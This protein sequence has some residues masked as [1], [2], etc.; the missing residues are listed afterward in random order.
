[1]TPHHLFLNDDV[2]KSFDTNTKMNPPLGNEE[3]RAA[4]E[5]ALINGI[6]DCV[7]TD[8]APHTETEKQV[9]YSFAPNG[10]IGLET[11]LS[12]MLTRL[13]HTKKM[14]PMQM[15]QVMSSNPAN[16]LGINAGSLKRESPADIT[17]IDPDRFWMVDPQA[18]H[19]KSR[20][21]PFGGL[22]LRG[23][24]VTTI[25]NGKIVYQLQE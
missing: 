25:V 20:N 10:V 7:A 1:M 14:S 19:S 23:S 6:I 21:T 18:F 16:I 8:H 5:D 24:C 13:V 11:A 15:V 9:E 4:L 2:V 17:V 22:S 12:L 3:D